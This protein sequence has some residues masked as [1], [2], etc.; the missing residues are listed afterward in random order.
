MKRGNWKRWFS[1]LLTVVMVMSLSAGALA[2]ENPDNGEAD[3]AVTL[4]AQPDAD[5]AGEGDPQTVSPA[6]EDQAEGDA[7]DSDEPGDTASDEPGDTEEETGPAPWVTVTV[8]LDKVN[9]KKY[10]NG[11]NDGMFHPDSP[12]TRAEA[13]QIINSL[14]TG[15]T[16]ADIIANTTFSDVPSN[17]WYTPAVNKLASYGVMSGNEGKFYPNNNI[18]RAEFVTILSRFEELSESTRTFTDVSEDFWGY[19]QVISAAEKGWVNGYEDGTFL[20]N[21]TLTRAEAVTI[22]NRVLQRYPDYTS[23]SN[24]TAIRFFPD[25]LS[26]HWAYTQVMEA[27]Q[28]HEYSKYGYSENWSNVQHEKTVL[29]PGYHLIKGALYYVDGN[30]DFALDKAVEGH[31]FDTT[32]RYTT[33]NG[34]LD[35]LMRTETLKFAKDGMSR[36]QLL[37]AMFNHMIS[38]KNFT[39]LSREKLVGGATGWEE[40]Y[41]IPMLQGRRGNCYSYASVT[42]F[43]AKNIGYDPRAVAGYVGHNRAPHGWI[44]LVQNGVTYIYD[45]ELTMAKRLKGYNYYLFKM[46]YSSAPFIY[47]KR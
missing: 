33:G 14:I 38:T 44:E 46:T 19:R 24:R 23:I 41:A 34:T 20:P 7:A 45:T 42:F 4:T 16:D 17:A 36:E 25:L 2:E 13:A 43:L 15:V 12:L 18:T 26:S 6:P 22:I 9:H 1:I 39:Y 32:G 27:S 10:I 29:S 21:K 30:G 47:A 11:S 3:A 40:R 28:T 37:Q 35:T 5:A 31:W 8:K